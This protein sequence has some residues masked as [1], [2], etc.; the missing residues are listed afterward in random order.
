MAELWALQDLSEM[1]WAFSKVFPCWLARR[2][3]STAW[4]L[5]SHQLIDPEFLIPQALRFLAL[6][7]SY[8]HKA[9]GGP[10]GRVLEL[11][12]RAAPS[13]AIPCPT[14][15]AS[16]QPLSLISV[17][18]T[19]CGQCSLWVLS[20]LPQFGKCTRQRA[21]LN[22]AFTLCVSFLPRSKALLCPMPVTSW[23]KSFI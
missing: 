17:S 1:L 16:S 13:S 23:Y 21:L 6:H 15:S 4:P 8:L 18:S 11:L 12:L 9:S 5:K 19:Q 7:T 2:A 22:V 14:G 3:L 10:L 20:P